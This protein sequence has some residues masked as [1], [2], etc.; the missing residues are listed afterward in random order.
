[1]PTRHRLKLANSPLRFVTTTCNNWLPV[2]G[3][4]QSMKIVSES[5]NFVSAK[6]KADILG[7]VLMP[8]HIHLL[9]FLGKPDT[10]SSFMRDFK[11]FTSTMLYRQLKGSGSELLSELDFRKDGQKIKIWKDRF[12]DFTITQPDTLKTKLNYIHQNPVRKELSETPEA[13][14]YSSARFYNE[15]EPGMIKLT[16]YLEAVGVASQYSYGVI[17]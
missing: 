10:L 1:M 9:L 3:D 5:L 14:P 16:H 13:Y 6:Y 8:N 15:E 4:Q 12:D 11:K 7:Y 17:Y 2:L